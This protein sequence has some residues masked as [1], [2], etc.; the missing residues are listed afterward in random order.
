MARV[1][2]NPHA[3]TE[4]PKRRRFDPWVEKIPWRQAWQPTPVFLPGG[5]QGWRSLADYGPVL[6][7]V[8]QD[9]S[10]L[11]HTHIIGYSCFTVLCYFPLY[12]EVNQLSGY[13]HRLPL[14]HSSHPSG[15]S[16]RRAELSA[17]ARSS[18]L[19]LCLSQGCVYLSIPASQYVPHFLPP[20]P[21]I[22]SLFPPCKQIHQFGQYKMV[23]RKHRQNTLWH[24]S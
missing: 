13:I 3:D 9:W 7:R 14:G 20:H 15:S 19:A 12:S 1:V 11:A 10:N 18:P 4:W 23:T 6:K 17:L 2:K 21:H 24:K 8:G 22:C 16:E 5:S